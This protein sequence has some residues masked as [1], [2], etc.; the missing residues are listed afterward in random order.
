MI[1]KE[2]I[3]DDIYELWFGYPVIQGNLNIQLKERVKM[4]FD[5]VNLRF[6]IS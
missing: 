3:I 1:L 4:I 2:K 5:I 6:H